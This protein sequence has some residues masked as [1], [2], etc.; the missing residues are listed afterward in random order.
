VT[1]PPSRSA[2][3]DGRCPLD[4]TGNGGE[5]SWR[6]ELAGAA[7]TAADHAVATAGRVR[8]RHT[9][10]CPNALESANGEQLAAMIGD[11]AARYALIRQASNPAA[12]LE[13]GRWIRQTEDNPVF[14][15]RF[16]HARLSAVG[17]Y[18]VALGYRTATEPDAG[19]GQP[20]VPLLPAVTAAGSPEE[21]AMSAFHAAVQQYP[22]ALA[23]A[24]DRRQ[25]HR[26]TRYLERLAGASRDYLT[27]VRVLPINERADGG[28]AAAAKRLQ[29]VGQARWVLAD[30]L[31]V[32]GV[33]APERL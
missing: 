19:P 23:D 6:D 1:V 11:D 4:R 31:R 5:L 28:S 14:L 17:R 16:A 7:I 13:V 8:L 22:A 10:D 3:G 2:R 32:L 15:V 33:T 18:A 30:G 26:L 12:P 25:P 20:A 24:G 9:H 29:L 21:K 27:S